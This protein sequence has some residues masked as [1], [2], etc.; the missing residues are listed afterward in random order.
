VEARKA[1]LR[2]I[3]L[4][5]PSPRVVKPMYGSGWSA[6]HKGINLLASDGVQPEQL[7]VLIDALLTW[8]RGTY[9][10]TPLKLH[11]NLDEVHLTLLQ[12]Q[13]HPAMKGTTHAA[14]QSDPGG[15]P[16]PG[17]TGG[18]RDPTFFLIQPWRLSAAVQ[19]AGEVAPG[20][21]LPGL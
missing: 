15:N 20:E 7:G 6:F 18:G 17:D 12:R 11:H 14:S 8:S 10:P 21:A 5:H 19:G 16:A 9:L 1:E 2:A 3:W 13:A 4:A